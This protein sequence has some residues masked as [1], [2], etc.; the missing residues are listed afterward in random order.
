MGAASAPSLFGQWL[1]R[2]LAKVASVKAYVQTKTHHM[3]YAMGFRV[4][5]EILADDQFDIVSRI[6][7]DLRRQTIEAQ[8][9]FAA[10]IFE[11]ISK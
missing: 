9:E 10:S 6:S 3:T 2:G 5:S 8:D 4:T 7:E 11:D 1:E